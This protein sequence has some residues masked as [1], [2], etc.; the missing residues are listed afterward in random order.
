MS[1]LTDIQTSSDKG[2]RH[3]YLHLY[4]RMLHSLNPRKILEVGIW[5]GDS[6]KMWKE[7]WPDAEVFGIDLIEQGF[8]GEGI[9]TFVGDAYTQPEL[10]LLLKLAPFDFISDDGSH[11]LDHQ[12]WFVSNYWQLLSSRG[13][14]MMVE[15]VKSSDHFYDLTWALPEALRPYSFGC[16]VRPVAPQRGI[17]DHL[18]WF[19]D[20][21]GAPE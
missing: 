11:Q 16:D 12:I 3:G 19:L 1:A 13:A 15:D 21:R 14:V 10:N 6:L 5:Q 9:Q 4:E 20:T 2:W 7:R 8:L 18:V 17:N